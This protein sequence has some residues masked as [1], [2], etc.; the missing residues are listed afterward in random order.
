MHTA[1][2]ATTVAMSTVTSPLFWTS[3]IIDELLKIGAELYITSRIARGDKE[4]PNIINKE[5]LAA[6]ELHPRDI[7]INSMSKKLE[8]GDII[9]G[10]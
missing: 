3:E 2:A 6:S 10:H 4:H 5:H 1:N 9:C 7:M 8:F